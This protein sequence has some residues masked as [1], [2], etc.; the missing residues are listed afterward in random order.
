MAPARTSR[1]AAAKENGT[2]AKAGADP[3]NPVKR[4]RGRPPK[5]GVSAQPKRTPTGR[6]RGRPPGGG[7]KKAT[8]AKPASATTGTGR[9]RGRPAGKASASTTPKKSASKTKKATPAGRGR[10]RKSDA[11]EEPE[12]EEEEDEEQEELEL[13]EKDADGEDSPVDGDIAMGDDDAENAGEEDDEALPTL[14]NV[15]S[16]AYVQSLLASALRRISGIQG[17]R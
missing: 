7:V 17:T 8:A 15:A 14:E 4:G 2:A 13:G 6:P 9:G 1:V 11:A 5:N 12:E 16:P 10:K 3:E